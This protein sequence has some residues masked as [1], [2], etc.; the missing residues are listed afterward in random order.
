MCSVGTATI[1]CAF[2]DNTEKEGKIKSTT[3]DIFDDQ[4]SNF[5]VLSCWDAILV[6]PFDEGKFTG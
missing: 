5:A 3:F 6:R 4:C 1:S 2:D